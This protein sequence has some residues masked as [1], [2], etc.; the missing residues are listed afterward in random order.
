[1]A[2][3][4]SGLHSLPAAPE[5]VAWFIAHTKQW[6]TERFFNPSSKPVCRARPDPVPRIDRF[7]SRSVHDAVG[8]RA[9]RGFWTG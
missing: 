1:M 3:R 5:A 4:K 7:A 6:A 2:V 8:R 9:R